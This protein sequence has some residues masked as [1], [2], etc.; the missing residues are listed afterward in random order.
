MHLDI[1]GAL[2]HD[3]GVRTT[4]TINDDVARELHR[5]ER[6]TQRTFK[7]IVN[8]LLRRGLAAGDR[9]LPKPARFVVEAKASG[10][11]PGIDPLKLNQLVDELETGRFPA[12]RPS[13]R[14][15]K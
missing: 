9:P 12:I 11:Q 10:F 15:T 4:L 6:A 8:D 7:E 3:A 13:R 5:L 2:H 14:K 1:S